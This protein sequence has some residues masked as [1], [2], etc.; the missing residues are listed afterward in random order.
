MLD[1]MA[2]VKV[3]GYAGLE[4]SLNRS[5]TSSMYST[6]VFCTKLLAGPECH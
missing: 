6:G 4:T 5:Q 3:S 2:L 1:T